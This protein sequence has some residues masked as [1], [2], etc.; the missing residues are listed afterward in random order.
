MKVLSI[1]GH[2]AFGKKCI[3]GQTVKTKII[4][5][6]LELQLGEEQVLKIDTHGK[7][8]TLLKAPFQVLKALKYGRNTLIFPAHNGIKVFVPLLSFFKRFFKN[9]RLHYV[10]IGGWLPELLKQKKFLIKSLYRFYGIYVETNT[11]K[12]ELE[13]L[14]LKNVYVVPNCKNLNVLSVE[15]LTYPTTMPY[16]LCIFSRVMREKG[17][18]TAIKV[19]TRINEKLG[20]VYSLDIYGPIDQNQGEWFDDL[21]KKFPNFVRYCGCV[22][23]NKSVEV[24]KDYFALLFPTHFYT[25]GIPGTIIDAYAAGLPVISAR[26][27]SFADVVDD[28]I[29]GYGYDFEDEEHFEQIL[30]DIV[31]S[32]E[33]IL[34]LKANC[35]NK[36]KSYLPEEVI[37]KIT[38]N[39]K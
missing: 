29:T 3:D 11:M 21:Q 18:E 20:T 8:K 2:F 4:T 35:I 16:K 10:V 33:K 5:D 6:E 9:R 32:P 1:I 23:A 14:G 36:A 30:Q 31:N 37:Y 24:L 34:S 26:W 17:I 15:K 19:I 13:K 38:R 39:L 25:E 12:I 22:D 28:G 7:Y 27:A